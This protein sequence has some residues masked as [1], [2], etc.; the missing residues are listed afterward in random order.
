MTPSTQI[1]N[2]KLPS[3]QDASCRTFGAE[4]L[5]A[6]KEVLDSGTLITTK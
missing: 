4:E 3:D 1:E 6:I 2:I 5:A